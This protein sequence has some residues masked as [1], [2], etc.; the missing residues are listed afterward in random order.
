MRFEDYRDEKMGELHGVVEENRCCYG[1][2]ST[3]EE[4][5]T[6]LQAGTI[7]CHQKMLSYFPGNR[8]QSVAQHGSGQLTEVHVKNVCRQ[9]QCQD[10]FLL[11]F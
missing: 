9:D 1:G 5:N 3:T 4:I 11:T 2:R 10:L 7:Q 8:S 6:A